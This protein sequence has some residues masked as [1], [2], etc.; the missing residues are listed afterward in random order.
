MSGDDARRDRLVAEL[1]RAPKAR[2][3][4]PAFLARL[5]DRELREPGR[6][7]REVLKRA[8]RSLHQVGGAYLAPTMR[9]DRWLADLAEAEPGPA[10]LDRLRS[11]LGQHNST[12]ERLDRLGDYYAALF[13]GIE[14][15]DTILDLACGFNPLG[16]ARMPV[17]PMRYLGCDVYLDLLAFVTAAGDLLGHPVETFAH[18]LVDGP[19]PR[20]ADVVLLLKTL[21]CLDQLDRDVSRRLLTDL[22]A[23]TVLVTFPVRSLGGRPKGMRGFYRDRFAELVDGLDYTVA[24]LDLP[25]EL[26]FRLRRPATAD[27]RSPRAR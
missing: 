17:T 14:A 22:F 2:H 10:R 23:P 1:Q 18:D 11:V 8:K 19:P 26:G 25:V 20:P 13:D 24:E 15:P 21:P 5:C 12:A 6:S 4:M 9:Y 7:D 3:V 27:R 16:R